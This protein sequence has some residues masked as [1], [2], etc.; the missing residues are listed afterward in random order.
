M[1]DKILNPLTGRYVKKTGKIG[2]KLLAKIFIHDV[3][4]TIGKKY[5]KFKDFVNLKKLD[6]KEINANPNAISLLEK[7]VNKIDWEYLSLNSNAIRLL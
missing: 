2:K 1:D 3:I 6:W 4:P 5:T 7:N